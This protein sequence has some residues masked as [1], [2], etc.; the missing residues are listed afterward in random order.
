MFYVRGRAWF[1]NP[2]L[3]W[4]LLLLLLHSPSSVLLAYWEKKERGLCSLGP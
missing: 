2:P 4:L 1:L 3:G